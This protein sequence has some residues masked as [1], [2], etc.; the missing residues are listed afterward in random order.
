[1][2]RRTIVTYEPALSK[3]PALP[4]QPLLS[5]ANDDFDEA[6]EHVAVSLRTRRDKPGRRELTDNE[7]KRGP[8]SN[9]SPA[10]TSTGIGTIAAAGYR[11]VLRPPDDLRLRSEWFSRFPRT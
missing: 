11:F 2:T 5:F 1:M 6:L 7:P 3:T 4:R 9:D 8:R 10:A